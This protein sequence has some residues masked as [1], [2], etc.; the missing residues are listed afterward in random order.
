M[1]AYV[2]P[3]ANVTVRN[4]DPDAALR[5]S[6]IWNGSEYKRG[7]DPIDFIQ[8]AETNSKIYTD[9]QL[10][11][12]VKRGINIF[13][14][15]D[16]LIGKYYY[17]QTGEIG[18]A[19]QSFCAAKLIVVEPSTEYRVPTFY[20]QQFAFFDKKKIFQAKRMR[21]QI[22]LKLQRQPMLNIWYDS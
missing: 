2:P 20:G 16:A 12:F 7:Y 11:N 3:K 13:D 15:S 14:K 5:G 17:W 18:D 19:D 4:N 10:N 6:Y 22:I 9:D 8:Q 1:I 21:L